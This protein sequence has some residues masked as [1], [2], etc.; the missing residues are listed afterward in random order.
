MFG[1][2][3]DNKLKG[4]SMK[5][6]LKSFSG[7]FLCLFLSNLLSLPALAEAPQKKF[8]LKLTGGLTYMGLGDWNAHILDWNSS[9]RRSVEADGGSII[10]ENKTL[11]W[12]GEISGDVLCNLSSRFA[13]SIGVGFLSGRQ[14][15]GAETLRDTVTGKNTIDTK[16]SASSIRAGGFYYIPMFSQ[17]RISLG[18]GLGYYFAKFDEFYRREPGDG[19]W[20]DSDFD[21]KGGGL[22]FDGTVGFEYS[23]SKNIVLVVE[24]YGRYAKVILWLWMQR[25]SFGK[26]AGTGHLVARVQ[27]C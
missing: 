24:G 7:L 11:H 15:D 23:V 5:I 1:S 12:G 13:L 18:A 3:W 14:K 20:I 21:G 8:E 6:Y 22:G 25:I 16:V 17:A 19:Y 2:H 26:G 27:Y 4:G 9:R 10:K